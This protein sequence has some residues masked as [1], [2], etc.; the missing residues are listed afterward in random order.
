MGSDYRLYFIRHGETDWNA[1][2]RLQGQQDIPI[3]ERGRF[4]AVEAGRKLGKLAPHAGELRWNVSPLWR[5][6]DTAERARRALHLDPDGYE[7][8]PILKEISFGDWEGRTWRELRKAEPEAAAER[9]SRKWTY[10]PPGG[11]SYAMLTDRVRP[12]AEALA[13]E[14]VA[15][16]HGGVARALLVLLCGLPAE[17]ACSADIWQGRVLLFEKGRFS[18][19]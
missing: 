6:R 5:T 3:N 15:V 11:E 8:D 17:R 7:L 19:I 9:E 14:S 12:F 1:E 16:A 13:G 4:Q 10:V 2:G 18:W